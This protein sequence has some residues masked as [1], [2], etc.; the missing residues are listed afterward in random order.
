[1]LASVRDTNAA[2]IYLSQCRSLL[3]WYPVLAEL[4]LG[5]TAGNA[6]EL[7]KILCWHVRQIDPAALAVAQANYYEKLLSETRDPRVYEPVLTKLLAARGLAH[8]VQPFVRG[9]AVCR[10]VLRPH[11]QSPRARARHGRCGGVA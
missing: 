4:G 6:E 5:P 10:P 7:F 8:K 9:S 1:M 2:A 3:G 11:H